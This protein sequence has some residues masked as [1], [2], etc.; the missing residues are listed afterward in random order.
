MLPRLSAQPHGMV[1]ADQEGKHYTTVS[2]GED[3]V[4][5][6]F[7]FDACKQSEIVSCSVPT[8]G[9]VRDGGALT[10]SLRASM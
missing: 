9:F 3:S 8:A 10:T 6:V 1:S 2:H 5:S 4:F 7:Y